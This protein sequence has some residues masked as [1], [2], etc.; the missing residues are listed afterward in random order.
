MQIR[1]FIITALILQCLIGIAILDEANDINKRHQQSESTSSNKAFPFPE[2]PMMN[3]RASFSDN[4]ENS[5]YIR[6]PDEYPVAAKSG[7]DLGE[8]FEISLQFLFNTQ[9]IL[10][11]IYEY[12]LFKQNQKTRYLAIFNHSKILVLC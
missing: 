12:K 1:N 5:K 4:T 10:F 9:T 11:V 7:I 8:Y 6:G 3:S 2:L